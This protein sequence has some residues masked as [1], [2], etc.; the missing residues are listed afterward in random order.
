MY[1]ITTQNKFLRKVA[2]A[3]N[4]GSLFG[5]IKAG[6]ADANDFAS[7][8]QATGIDPRDLQA[9]QQAGRDIQNWQAGKAVPGY[10]PLKSFATIT[11][12]TSNPTFSKGY[13]EWSKTRAN[14]KWRPG[15]ENA[16]RY[17]DAMTYAQTNPS[18]FKALQKS[19]GMTPM[20]FIFDSTDNNYRFMKALNSP[21]G[22]F[23]NDKQRSQVRNNFGLMELIWRIKK[24]FSEFGNWRY[25]ADP[26]ELYRFN[27][28]R[29]AQRPN[30][31]NT[32]ATNPTVSANGSNTR[33]RKPLVKMPLEGA[34]GLK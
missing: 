27:N 9:M 33:T 30:I 17:H 13:A 19:R 32:K 28:W 7:L 1:Q 11:K 5:R 4:Q 23:L 29:P 12:V 14:H 6:F 24:F 31:N 15:L 18:E 10:D 3:D 20:N 26:S 2:K 34:Q 8:Q 25:Q 22:I 21:M 16:L